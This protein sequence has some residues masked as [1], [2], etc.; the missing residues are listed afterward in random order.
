VL[1]IHAFRVITVVRRLQVH[2]LVKGFATEIVQML[3]TRK[4]NYVRS[5]SKAD[6]KPRIGFVCCGPKADKLNPIRI[7]SSVTSFK[8]A[9]ALIA[10]QSV[11]ALSPPA[12]RSIF[13][14]PPTFSFPVQ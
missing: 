13:P 8:K 1:G 10:H 5:G 3:N 4:T 14:L 2:W 12:P 7:T 11:A 9:V 6:I